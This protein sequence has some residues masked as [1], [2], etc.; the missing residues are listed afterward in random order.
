MRTGHAGTKDQP[1]QNRR[2][3]PHRSI[4]AMH[5]EGEWQSQRFKPASRTAAQR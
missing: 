3:N 5:R 1:R 2:A 4:D